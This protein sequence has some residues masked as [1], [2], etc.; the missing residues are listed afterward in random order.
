MYNIYWWC[1]SIILAYT[2]SKNQTLLLH[3]KYF[4]HRCSS[5]D[6]GTEP[7]SHQ[8]PGT[9]K[10]PLVHKSCARFRSIWQRLK[11]IISLN[12]LSINVMFVLSLVLNSHY[13]SHSHSQQ[14]FHRFEFVFIAKWEN[15]ILLATTQNYF[16]ANVNVSNYIYIYMLIRIHIETENLYISL[17]VAS[18]C[19]CNSDEYTKHMV[20]LFY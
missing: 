5:F 16:R 18:V 7:Q 11:K 20:L 15:D 12:L 17:R 13:H 8:Q 6:I 4:D 9:T 3:K 1:M 19:V 2:S 10:M 14:Q